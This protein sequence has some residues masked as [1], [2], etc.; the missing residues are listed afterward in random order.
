MRKLRYDSEKNAFKLDADLWKK[1]IKIVN[2]Y[3][4]AYNLTF[5]DID[6]NT[7]EIKKYSQL[8]YGKK[9]SLSSH[10]ILDVS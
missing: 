7:K 3:G 5:N 2:L 4:Y 8:S 10:N 9:C 6:F 1:D